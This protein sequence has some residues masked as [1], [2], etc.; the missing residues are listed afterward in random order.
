MDVWIIILA[1]LF[2]IIFA[3]I[4]KIVFMMEDK[5]WAETALKQKAE[6]LSKKEDTLYTERLM[7]YEEV[8]RLKK[9]LEQYIEANKKLS[10]KRTTNVVIE[11]CYLEP[12]EVG[13]S[14]KFPLDIPTSVAEDTV[15]RYMKDVLFDHAKSQIK[16]V[17]SYD[18]VSTMNEVT[19]RVL[20]A[21]HV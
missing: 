7:F 2:A 18:P 3:L 19:A 12:E 8:D 15:E 20:V 5:E 11:Q 9:Q 4:I 17:T 13:V 14:V 6:E 21:Y 1:I 16:S 10:D